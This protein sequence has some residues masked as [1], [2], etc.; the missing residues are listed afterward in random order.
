M[1]DKHTGALLSVNLWGDRWGRGKDESGTRGA[2][3]F[4]FLG[5]LEDVFSE[6]RLPAS[7]ILMFSPKSSPGTLLCAVGRATVLYTVAP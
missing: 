6:T 4:S 7:L 3:G 2:R 1:G 5:C